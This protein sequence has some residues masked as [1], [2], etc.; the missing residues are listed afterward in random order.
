MSKLSL[1]LHRYILFPVLLIS[2]FV[3]CIEREMTTTVEPGS[4]DCFYQF[5]KTGET[6]DIEYQV[7]DGGHGDLDISFEIAE[8]NG[9]VAYADFKKSDNIHR[10]KASTDGD[11]RFC[12]DNTFSS[13][14][15][16]TVFFEI[17]I[18][19]E[20]G[21]SD[22]DDWNNDIFEGLSPEEYYDMKVEDIQNAI[23]R[24]RTYLSKARQTQDILKSFEARDRN[25]AEENYFRVNAWSI[26]QILLMLG[27]GSVQVFM[28]RSLFETDSKVNTIWKK[29]SL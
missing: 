25:I 27:V 11:Y 1:S 12:F 21:N 28:V 8:P 4:K 17:I 6:L 3:S 24:V 22:N 26:C 19:S 18:E 15:R 9:R 23:N 20:D 14:N 5:L 13:F 16:K 7:I 10:H 29:L 2:Q